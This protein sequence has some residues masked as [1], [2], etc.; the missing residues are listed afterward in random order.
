MPF[1]RR[2]IG[3]PFFTSGAVSKTVPSNAAMVARETAA[4]LADAVPEGR[5]RM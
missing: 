2:R 3:L 1:A 4:A 5:M